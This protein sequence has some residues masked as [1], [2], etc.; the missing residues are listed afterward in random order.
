LII[1]IGSLGRRA[2]LDLRC[3]FIDRFG[4]LSK[5][6]LMRFLYVDCDTDALR[7]SFRGASEVALKPS[8]IYHLPLQTVT[9]YRRRQLEHLGEWLPREKLYA[10]P[11]SLKTQGSRA[12]GRLAFSDNYHRFVTRLKRELQQAAHPDAVYQSV[13]HTGLALR[14]TTPR[15]YV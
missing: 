9:H 3:R 8:E 5:L 6:P 11:R 12:L 15:V 10:M 7:A 14:D 13:N 2:L 4:D 1:G